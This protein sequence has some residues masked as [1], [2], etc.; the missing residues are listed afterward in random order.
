[1]PSLTVRDS[2]KKSL[3]ETKASKLP[4]HLHCDWPVE[5]CE[6]TGVWRG[7]NHSLLFETACLKSSSQMHFLEQVLAE[8]TAFLTAR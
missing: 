5:A 2:A 3:S 6:S 7:G 1:M 8:A 4:V